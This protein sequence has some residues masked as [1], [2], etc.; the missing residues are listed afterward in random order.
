[1]EPRAPGRVRYGARNVTL[2]FIAKSLSAANAS[3]R[4]MVDRTGMRGPFDFNLEWTPNP[5]TQPDLAGLAF[6]QA[7]RRQLGLKRVSQK[8][9][10]P[11][12]VLDHVER[13]TEN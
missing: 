3:G 13:P 1:M 8:A 4:P 7:L 2:E 5:D 11:V 9:S 6:E 12:L 10:M